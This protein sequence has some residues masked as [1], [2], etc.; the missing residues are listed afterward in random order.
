MSRG[1]TTLTGIADR[2]RG[3]LVLDCSA[4]WVACDVEGCDEVVIAADRTDA[5]DAIMA[6]EE[7]GWACEATGDVC[8]THRTMGA[9]R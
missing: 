4:A 8:E 9:G 6:A 1:V 7:E 5:G 3:R 2:R